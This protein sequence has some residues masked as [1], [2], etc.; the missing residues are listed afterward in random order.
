MREVEREA[1]RDRDRRSVGKKEGDRREGGEREQSHTF[2]V[3]PCYS[4]C[5]SKYTS[6][7][8]LVTIIGH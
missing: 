8:L 5:L 3:N 1:E 6:Y 2:R 7:L 4:T